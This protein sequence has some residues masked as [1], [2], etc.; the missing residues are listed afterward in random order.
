MIAAKY[1]QT[2][3]FDHK[4]VAGV[5]DYKKRPADVGDTQRGKVAKTGCPNSEKDE[6]SGDDILN[7]EWMEYLI[8]EKS[9]QSKTLY[10]VSNNMAVQLSTSPKESVVALSHSH[11]NALT[12]MLPKPALCIELFISTKTKV[13]FL[14]QTVDVENLF[15]HLPVLEYWIPATGIIKKTT[16]IISL[17]P[18][19]VLETQESLKTMG[20]YEEEI[21]RQIDIKANQK[22]VNKYKI[23]GGFAKEAV[24]AGNF[25]LL[26]D[27]TDSKPY[28]KYTYDAET[29]KYFLNTPARFKDERKITVGICRKDVLACRRKKKNVFYNCIAVV[30]RIIYKGEFREVHA[31]VFNTG[32]MEI[33][34]MFNDEILAI[35]RAMILSS[36]RP[37]VSS[38]AVPVLDYDKNGSNEEDDEQNVL[39][40]SNFHC[41]F[42]IQREKLHHILRGPK[43]QLDC[44]YDPCTYPGVKCKF[45]FNREIGFNQELQQGIIQENWMT[46]QEAENTPSIRDTYFEV[47]IMIFRTGSSLIGGNCTEKV[48]RFIFH[49]FAKILNDEYENIVLPTQK[50]CAS[51]ELKKP[52]KTKL[53]KRFIYVDSDI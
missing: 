37:Y 42:C 38:P 53:R 8:T 11:Q 6:D 7:D 15:L 35:T 48:L 52:K 26:L 24:A 29:N 51:L 17:T 19:R 12:Q 44:S 13:L 46:R 33:P 23:K 34:G 40:N 39:I 10:H 9:A 30:I 49:F 20:V 3:L 32:K 5:H 16:K 27:Y 2:R 31:K 28:P 1:T 21:L 45:Y 43:Y 25:P 22:Q 14:N 18:E 4:F 47:S 50:H 36:L 41:G